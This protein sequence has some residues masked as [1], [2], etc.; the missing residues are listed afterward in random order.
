MVPGRIHPATRVFQALRI[1]VNG[2]LEH[3][4]AGVAAAFELLRPGGRL[5]VISFHSL[6]DRIVKRFFQRLVKPCTCPPGLPV[7]AC[8]RKPRAELLTRKGVR[9]GEAETLVN[10]RARSAVLRGVRKVE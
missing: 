1:A 7:C 2:E 6:E 8:G 10:P 9:A 3:V 4:E 5:V